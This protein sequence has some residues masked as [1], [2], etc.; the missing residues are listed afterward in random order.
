MFN[1][2]ISHNMPEPET[3]ELEKEHLID[4]LKELEE[5][6]FSMVEI[7][8]VVYSKRSGW[9]SRITPK[10]R[11]KASDLESQLK[12][13]EKTPSGVILD[14][15]KGLVYIKAPMPGYWGNYKVTVAVYD[16][17]RSR[18]YAPI[19]TVIPND[20]MKLLKD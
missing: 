5:Y 19:S 3:K 17:D 8:P 13:G 14:S 20:L 4:F 2:F 12:S 11:F 18:K 10:D 9:I 16:A 15:D 1:C 7:T 6:N